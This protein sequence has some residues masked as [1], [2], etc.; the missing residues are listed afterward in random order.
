MVGP[1]PGQDEAKSPRFRP[2]TWM[3]RLN[4]SL[5]RDPEALELYI[6]ENGSAR[7]SPISIWEAHKSVI[8]GTLI[9]IA[10]QKRKAAMLEKAELYMS[11]SMLEH[12]HKR[13]Q[14]NEIYGEL[15][16]AEAKTEG[17]HYENT[18][19]HCSTKRA[20]TI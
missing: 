5:L 14:L 13:S 8:R 16:R 12:Q 3:W 19:A 10:S 7:T 17:P 11:I 20:F 15:I 1:Q 6:R 18:S 4:E 2:S 9:R